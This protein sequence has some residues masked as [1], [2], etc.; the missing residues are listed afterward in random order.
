[1][2]IAKKA[3]LVDINRLQDGALFVRSDEKLNELAES[4]RSK[5]FRQLHPPIVTPAREKYSIID[6]HRRV[7]AA[8][9]TSIEQIPVLIAKGKDVY[10]IAAAEFQNQRFSPMEEAEFFHRWIDN[11]NFSEKELAKLIKRTP[12]FISTRKKL[13]T[14]LD[15]SVKEMVRVR[16]L[17]PSKAEL[18][19]RLPIQF[20]QEFAEIVKKKKWN[21]GRVQRGVS[22]LE[23]SKDISMHIKF[24]SGPLKFDTSDPLPELIPSVTPA[25][26]AIISEKFRELPPEQSKLV[27]P[28]LDN[29]SK[30]FVVPGMGT[31]YSHVI[32][33]LHPIFRI[34]LVECEYCGK[35]ITHPVPE[36][37]TLFF[38]GTGYNYQVLGNGNTI[39]SGGSGGSLVVPLTEVFQGESLQVNAQTY[40]VGGA[41]VTIQLYVNGQLVARSAQSSICASTQINYVI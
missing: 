16:V 9:Q 19:A 22:D 28:E 6:G 17:D 12:E 40:C 25:E 37:V 1:L 3:K 39:S 36:N 8:R 18:I 35:R 21:V 20:Q 23:R 38:V 7:H 34:F 24:L 29:P 14:A 11:L 10:R 30:A 26:V 31:I 27:L 2:K 4:I 15:S 32:E 13:G 41:S 5:E 33:R